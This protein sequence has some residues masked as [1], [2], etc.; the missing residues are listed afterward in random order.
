MEGNSAPTWER[1][2]EGTRESSRIDLVIY[3]D[4][5]KWSPIRCTKLLLDHCVMH[6]DWEVDLTRKVEERA[7]G[8]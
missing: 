3:K 2:K 5:F 1:T 4:N 8:D 7:V 6:G